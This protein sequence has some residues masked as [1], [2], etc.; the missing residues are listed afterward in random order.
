MQTLI[1]VFCKGNLSSLRKKIANDENLTDYYLHVKQ[2]K[3]NSRQAGWLKLGADGGTNGT[4][5]IEWDA[6]TKILS[7]R[8]VNKGQGKPDRIAGDFV[9]YLIGRHNKNIKAIH[10]VSID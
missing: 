1:Q 6:K 3:N 7:T 10:I 5:N 2:H 4:L 9:S 8:V